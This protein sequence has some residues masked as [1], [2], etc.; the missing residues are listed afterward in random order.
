MIFHKSRCLQAW[1]F[2]IICLETHPRQ[3]PCRV[4]ALCPSVPLFNVYLIKKHVSLMT[5]VHFLFP[6]VRQGMAQ[7]IEN[8]IIFYS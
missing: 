4:R 3:T 2:S 7:L 6:I 8:H 5:T 1:Y